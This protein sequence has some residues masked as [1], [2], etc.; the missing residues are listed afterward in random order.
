[1]MMRMMKTCF[2]V[3]LGL[4][5][6]LVGC[7]EILDG[8]EAPLAE[9]DLPNCSRIITCCNN[10][11]GNGLAPSECQEIFIPAVETVIENYQLAQSR[12]SA[13]AE[14][15]RALRD[16]TQ[17]LV[18]PGCRCFLEETVGQVGDFLLPVDCESDKSVGDLESGQCSDATDGLLEAAGD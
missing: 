10:L 14:A 9:P 1:M 5:F 8:V 15:S 6:A 2:A 17:E 18:E 13:D 7:E 4:S 3:V 11:E 16:E 12:V